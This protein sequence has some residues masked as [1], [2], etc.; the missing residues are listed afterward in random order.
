[1]VSLFKK[2]A[3]L[4]KTVPTQKPPTGGGAGF[5]KGKTAGKGKG[6]KKK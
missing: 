5:G 3:D 1:M 6:K 2:A 4:K